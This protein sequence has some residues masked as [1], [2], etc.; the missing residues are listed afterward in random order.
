MTKNLAP[1][2]RFAPSP[3]GRLHIGNIRTALY[4]WLYCKKQG[5]QFVL[6]LDDTDQERSTDAFAAGIVEDLAWL[7]V[8]PDRTEKQSERFAKYDAVADDLRQ[9]GLLYACYESADEIDRR[10]KRLMAR[11]LPP[12]YDRAAL[13]LSDEEKAELEAQGR[14]PH[15]RFLLPNFAGSPFETQRSE[16]KFDDVMR[17]EQVVDLASMSD[18][19][20]IREDGTYLYT[21]PSVV[22]DIEFGVTHVIRGGDHITNTGAQITIFEAVGGGGESGDGGGSVPE[23]GHHNL[24]QDASGEGLSKRT[25]ALS[26][27]SLRDEGYEPM[28][29]AS[30][31]TLIGTGQPVE[32]CPDMQTL[33]EVFDPSK[34]SKSNAK[35]SVS[36]L[37]GLNDKL[38]HGMA[39]SQAAPR[40]AEL[41]A[42]LG[43]AF[44]LA[45]RPNISRFDQVR[46]WA[47]IVEGRFDSVPPA[48]EDADFVK[49]AA[50]LL[51]EEPWDAEVWPNWT[52]QLK[53]QT[54][55]K[56]KQLFMPLRLALTG[57]GHGP[58]MRQLMPVIG[59]ERTRRRLP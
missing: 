33:A 59:L 6:R 3:T 13:N 35:F 26:I 40:L 4:N 54:G 27:A 16:V 8:V 1:I 25:G 42:D 7:G 12:V 28:A 48:P 29:V 46:E 5:G 53:Q 31:A 19:V 11:G 55:R 2:V 51:P 52:S 32:A 15:W 56:G 47:D 50:E 22:D 36:D 18:P 37:D 23:F 9:K 45:V 58:D 43:E 49:L 30:L 34:V 44:W 57:Q 38:L 39:Y 20:L 10:R 24:L 14:R 17:G 21:L 41:N